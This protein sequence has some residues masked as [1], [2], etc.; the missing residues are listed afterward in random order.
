MRHDAAGSRPTIDRF[1]LF[2]LLWALLLSSAGHAQDAP[3][4]PCRDDDRGCAAEALRGHVVTTLEYWRPALERPVEERI[5]SAPPELLEYVALDNIKGGITQ[6]PRAAV[7]SSDFMS[8]VQAALAEIPP[9]VR[10]RLLDKLAGIYFVENLGGT[11][12]TDYVFGER[13]SA[14]AAFVILDLEVLAVRTANAWATWKESSPFKAQVGYR[15]AAVIESGRNDNR[16]NAIQYILLHEL[17][18]VLA[19]AERLHPP[20]NVEPK[21]VPVDG[22]YRYFDL[23]W[24]VA[25]DDNRYVTIFDGFFSE[26][27]DIVYYFGAKLPAGNML[28]AYRNLER[29]SFTTLYAAT[30]P[31]D[32]FAEAFASYVHAVLMKKPFAIRIYRNGRLAKTYRSCWTQQR[33]AEKRRLLETFLGRR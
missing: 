20:W 28:S 6:K 13:A 4:L 1:S 12:Y 24:R 10:R 23:S 15:L 5:A 17:G 8:D 26:R 18:H 33:C 11:G 32:D 27:R 2:F 3:R 14:A 19:V 30:H 31:A 22:G 25:R 21:D 9:F 16:K 29:T 7:P